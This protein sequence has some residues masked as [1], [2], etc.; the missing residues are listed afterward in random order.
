M[1][2]NAALLDLWT[3]P[4]ERECLPCYLTR[5]LAD[6][7]CDGTT[8]W[9]AHWCHLRAPGVKTLDRTVR[10]APCDC[11]VAAAMGAPP[12]GAEHARDAAPRSSPPP[13]AGVRRGSVRPCALREGPPP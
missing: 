13:C 11:A 4:Q 10:R 1:T 12:T 7:G 6:F 8:R 3:E 5:V 9:A 2:H